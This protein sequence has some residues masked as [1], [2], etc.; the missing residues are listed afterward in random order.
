MSENTGRIVCANTWPSP[1]TR[2]QLTGTL[3]Q[4]IAAQDA[5]RSQMPDGSLGSFP[6]TSELIALRRLADIVRGQ[7]T[8]E[9]TV[10]TPVA[11]ALAAADAETEFHYDALCNL[12]DAVRAELAARPVTP[13]TE[14]LANVDE[15]RTELISVQ[16][17]GAEEFSSEEDTYLGAL[18]I[19]DA[20]VREH[21][22]P[23]RD[24]DELAAEAE[25]AARTA[26]PP[27]PGVTQNMGYTV[28]AVLPG[29]P[30]GD[31]RLESWHVAAQDER[32]ET[33]VWTAYNDDDGTLHYEGGSYSQDTSRDEALAE[34][35]RRGGV[36]SAM[37][38]LNASEASQ[39]A[40]RDSHAAA[41][42][43]LRD[44][45]ELAGPVVRDALTQAA[46]LGY[47]LLSR[48]GRG[49]WAIRYDRARCTLSVSR[50]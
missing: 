10:V 33:V 2:T 31:G 22:S 43:R 39:A 3:N 6:L 1:D 24:A 5:A 7:L 25:R 9:R 46:A 27:V 17:E 18:E 11:K 20:T 48:P 47:H 44:S 8:A 34:L 28:F 21:L 19:L 40:Y 16:Q 41:F 50:H 29:D 45:T 42:T 23:A 13:L 26:A 14:A 49:S 32:G 36:F 4:I 37:D 12:A 15:T 35:A 30:G 38:R